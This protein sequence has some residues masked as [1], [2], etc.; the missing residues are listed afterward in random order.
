MRL[1]RIYHLYSLELD[2]LTSG[3]MSKDMRS[4]RVK[5]IQQGRAKSRSLVNLAR[6]VVWCCRSCGRTV[7]AHVDNHVYGFH[8]VIRGPEATH[9]TEHGVGEDALLQVYYL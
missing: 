3:R 1:G 9:T 7:D 5:S 4:N 8:D 6:R 2:T